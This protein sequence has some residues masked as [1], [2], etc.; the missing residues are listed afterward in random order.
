MRTFLINLDIVNEELQ[1]E[2]LGFIL[3]K[4]IKFKKLD[5]VNDK[6][7]KK[8]LFLEPENK[9]EESNLKEFMKKNDIVSLTILDS[10]KVLDGIKTIGK[11]KILKGV[12][13]NYY[14]DKITGKKFIITKA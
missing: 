3:T 8:A 5:K 11:L 9:T 6:Q 14:L 13:E 2:I 7:V 12:S 10:A 1:K 4:G